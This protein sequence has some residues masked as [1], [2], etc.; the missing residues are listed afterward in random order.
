MSKIKDRKPREI[1]QLKSFDQIMREA[2]EKA[3]EYPAQP[4]T[5]ELINEH[6]KPYSKGIIIWHEN[7]GL[8][9]EKR[10]TVEE[11]IGGYVQI[12]RGKEKEPRLM[13]G[14]KDGGG[15]RLRENTAIFC[16]PQGLALQRLYCVEE[17]ETFMY[18]SMTFR[19]LSMKETEELLHMRVFRFAFSDYD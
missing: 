10:L 19:R 14:D 17:G 8:E 18:R 7:A 11:V 4:L 1:K 3:R 16:W 6:K 13:V 12:T 9:P 15:Y 5:P 2:D